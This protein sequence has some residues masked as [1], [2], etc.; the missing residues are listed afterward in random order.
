M[1]RIDVAAVKL[2]V[3]EIMLGHSHTDS[4]SIQHIKYAR[5]HDVHFVDVSSRSAHVIHI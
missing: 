5:T 2:Q 4:S 3:E 1:G